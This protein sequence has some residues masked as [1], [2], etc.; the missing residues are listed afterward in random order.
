MLETMNMKGALAA[1]LAAL[2]AAAAILGNGNAVRAAGNTE[3]EKIWIA[4]TEGTVSVKNRTGKTQSTAD[5]MRL[6]SGSNIA[7]AAASYAWLGLDDTK[8]VKL[9]E[10]TDVVITKNSG[11]LDIT[12]NEDVLSRT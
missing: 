7:T 1:G 2:M 6:F 10:K 8:S 11:N 3:A 12:L 9:D 5:G 4:K